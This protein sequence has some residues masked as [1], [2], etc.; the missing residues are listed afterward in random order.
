MALAAGLSAGTDRAAVAADEP[1]SGQ[2]VVVTGRREGYAVEETRTATRTP[3]ELKDVP[4]AVTAATEEQIEDRAFR[5]VSDVLRAVP[6]AS[7]AQGE[8]HRDQVVLR[9]N[10]STADFFVDGLRDD[11]QYYRPLYN[12]DRV[13][14]LRGPS[15]MTFGRGGGGGVVNRVTKQPLFET[16]GAGTAS[17]D[18]FGAW[19]LDADANLP[20]SEQV[21]ARV[22]AYREEFRNHRDVFDGRAFAVNPTVRAL[23]GPST[24]VALSYEYVDDARVVDRGVP[25]QGGRPLRG[26][27]DTFF[28][29]EGANELGLEAH[30][31]R[32]TAEHR[33]SDDFG[34][35]SRLQYADYDK[36]YRNVFPN[37]LAGT[38]AAPT[39]A[40]GAYFD[41]QKR[42][43][44]LS[45][46]DLTWRAS[47][48]AAR[49]LILLGV[50]FGDQRT[51]SDRL[52]GF[53]DG[54]AGA[55]MGGRQITRPLTDP[56]TAPAPVFRRGTGERSTASEADFF[57]LLAQDQV[58]IGP[59]E[60]LAGIRYDRFSLR[61]VNLYTG[62]RFRRTDELWSPRAGL[63]VHPVESVSLYGSYGR[64]YLP[65][66]GDQ[67]A[68]LDL[69]S[70]ALE[71]EKFENVEAGVKW[72]PR[73]GLLLAGA[74][75]QLD[76][77]NTRAAGP[78]PGEVV[79]TGAQ[80]SRGIELEAS[81]RVVPNLTV[82]AAYALQEAE[83]RRTTAAAPAGR[84]VA[85]VPKHQVSLWGRWDATPR[86]GLGAGVEHRSRQFTSIS[87]AVALPAY[88]RVDLAAFYR[89]SDKLEAQL[90][91]EN[92]FDDGYFPTAHSD[93]NISTGV[94]LNARLTIRAR[95]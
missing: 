14:V 33:P 53:W 12:L 35:V 8:G 34:L 79:L 58:T 18:S 52:N 55:T 39:V 26:F 76:R 60:I 87:N 22:N 74:V 9:G 68:S 94:P 81:G 71:P 10:N 62:E 49:H 11:A 27:R 28:G 25:S 80:R 69:T 23:F 16:F 13:E 91:V 78:N 50:E 64:S 56:F 93:N 65:Q 66:S 82:S 40:L 88:T 51:R 5:S 48:G 61:S 42:E 86:L 92:L 37:G 21:A 89:L 15:A 47:T 6:G 32:A 72:E 54:V 45:Q 4:Q 75:Y 31:L 83:I 84:N 95:L 19:Y 43:N 29:V 7:A 59:V 38:A 3:T 24:G 41:A 85:L 1:A 73:P 67:F 90:N 70:A 20:L 44:L 57:A 30:I 2:V 17:V 46:T 63:V 77:T 36:F